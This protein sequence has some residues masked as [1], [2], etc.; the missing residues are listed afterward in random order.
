MHCARYYRTYHDT[1]ADSVRYKGLR[2]FIEKGSS[3]YLDQRLVQR[4]RNVITVLVLVEDLDELL[5]KAPSGWRVHSLSGKRQNQWSV[6]VSGNWRIT[7]EER[8]GIIEHLNLE[9][10]H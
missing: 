9:D 6:S 7:F 8:G 5:E 10:Y 2:E 4:I 1:I 3:R